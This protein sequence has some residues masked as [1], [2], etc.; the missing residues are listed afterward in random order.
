M[1]LQVVKNVFR[2]M[3]EA[4]RRAL[5]S[6]F[7]YQARQVTE[8][9]ISRLPEFQ[10]GGYVIRW[11]GS[12]APNQDHPA[13]RIQT[14]K[15][16]INSPKGKFVFSSHVSTS[17][18]LNGDRWKPDGITLSFV[19]R[20][21]LV[22]ANVHPDVADRFTVRLWFPHTPQLTRGDQNLISMRAYPRIPRPRPQ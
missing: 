1:V 6:R 4:P 14:V 3:M 18:N 8:A 5:T 19:D 11:S 10:E 2:W 9:T 12:D 21:S 16:E 17:L 13:V 7:V 20:P 15:G 22:L